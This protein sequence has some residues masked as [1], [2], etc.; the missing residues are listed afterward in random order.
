LKK[1]GG[2]GG[3]FVLFLQVDRE[4]LFLF[5]VTIKAEKRGRKL[6]KVY[7]CFHLRVRELYK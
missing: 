2:G 6:S 4:P 7:L 5:K 1:D 3:D